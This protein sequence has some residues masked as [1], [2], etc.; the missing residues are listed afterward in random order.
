MAGKIKT[1]ICFASLICVL[2]ILFTSCDFRLKSKREVEKYLEKQY[3]QEFTVLSS[4]S[5]T[6]DYYND[7]VWR[8]MAY[9]VSPKDDPETQFFVFNTVEGES[10]GVPGFRNGLQD[11]YSLDI[12]GRAFETRAAETDVE[13]SFNYFYPVKSSSVYYSRLYL[14][15]VCTVLSQAYADTFGIVKDIPYGVTV[16]LTYREPAWS[17]DQSCLIKIDSLYFSR[18]DTNTET[19]EKYILD[20]V[21][22]Y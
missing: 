13:Y 15:M 22:K 3:G 21:G 7:D 4:E 6:D 5:V 11:T 17:E 18:F 8:V 10:F 14:E 2:A 9:T 19:I 16:N 1:R 12:F 20:E